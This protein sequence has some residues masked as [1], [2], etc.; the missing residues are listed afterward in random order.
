V[1]RATTL[2]RSLG[3][4]I[5]AMSLSSHAAKADEGGVSFWL[6]GLF[7]SLAAAPQQ[8]G[9]SLTS[10]Y[11]NTFVSASGNVALSREFELGQIPGMCLRI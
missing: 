1:A 10:I 11:Y 9:F 6:P 7:G 8:P 3:I 2:C 4:A 5:V